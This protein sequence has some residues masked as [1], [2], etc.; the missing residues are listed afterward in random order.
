MVGPGSGIA[1]FRA[2][3]QE[4]AG[5]AAEGFTIGPVLLFFGCRE[6]KFFNID[7]AFSRDGEQKVYVQDQFRERG[8]EARRLVVEQGAAFYIC[9]STKMAKDVKEVLIGSLTDSTWDKERAVRYVNQ[10]KKEHLFQ[11][12]T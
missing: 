11:E 6:H 8:R 10:M 3:V 12:D 9:G 4:R 1:P 5:L 2:F 7:C